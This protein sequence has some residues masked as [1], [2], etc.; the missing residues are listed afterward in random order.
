MSINLC[1]AR[2]EV[3]ALVQIMFIRMEE[4]EVLDQIAKRNLAHL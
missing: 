3:E 1:A 2:G 4:V